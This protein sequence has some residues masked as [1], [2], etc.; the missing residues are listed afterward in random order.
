MRGSRSIIDYIRVN[1]KLVS[2]VEDTRAWKRYDIFSDHFLLT[3]NI[4][5]HKQWEKQKNIG[6][7]QQ[8]NKPVFQV[9]GLEDEST[10]NL[11]QNRIN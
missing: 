9:H 4:Q 3:S 10:R 5:L 1:K 2:Q 11:Y 8:N 7:Q 6:Q